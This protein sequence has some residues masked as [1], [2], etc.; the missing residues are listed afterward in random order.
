MVPDGSPG[1]AKEKDTD[2]GDVSSGAVT[3]IWP[4][5]VVLAVAIGLALWSQSY[6]PVARR[7]PTAVSVILAILAIFDLWSRIDVPGRRAVTAVWGASFGNREMTHA[8][9]PRDEL[10]ITGWILAAFASAALFGILVALPLFCL[11]YVRLRGR[12]LWHAALVAAVL[13][14]FIYAVF[15]MLLDYE[16][17]RG[18]LFAGGGLRRW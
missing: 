7:F 3:S 17:Y 6:S 5:V 1:P 2:A 13:A 15:E 4:A 16:L 8:P 12:P 10:A 9:D 18:L 14:A 11:A